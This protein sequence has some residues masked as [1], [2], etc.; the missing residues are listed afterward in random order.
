MDLFQIHEFF[1]CKSMIFFVIRELFPIC[2][3]FKNIY[4]LFEFLKLFQKFI[5]FELFWDL[6]WVKFN[7]PN[8]STSQTGLSVNRSKRRA[9]EHCWATAR[10]GVLERHPTFP[11]L[12]AQKKSFF[13]LRGFIFT[14]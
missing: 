14:Y 2:K 10:P 3:P 13:V 8:R 12:K 11:V 7:G 9:S 5:F 1:S 4:D 6:S